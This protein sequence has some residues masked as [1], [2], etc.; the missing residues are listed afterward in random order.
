MHQ[1]DYGLLIPVSHLIPE[2][3]VK[4][5]RKRLERNNLK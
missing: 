1:N 5:V 2:K 4:V 3:V